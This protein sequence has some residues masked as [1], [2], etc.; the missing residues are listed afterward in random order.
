[1]FARWS[2]VVVFECTERQTARA[3]RSGVATLM[4]DSCILHADQGIQNMQKL[5]FRLQ[6]ATLQFKQSK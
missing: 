5:T 4:N 3:T 1:M 6:S 2:I